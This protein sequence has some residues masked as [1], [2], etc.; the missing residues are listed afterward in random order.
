MESLSNF[1]DPDLPQPGLTF[2]NKLFEFQQAFYSS[3]AKIQVLES[4]LQELC[5]ATQSLSAGLIDRDNVSTIEINGDL[6]DLSIIHDVL[7]SDYNAIP[8]NF[9]AKKLMDINSR[10]AQSDRIQESRG[11]CIWLEIRILIPGQI[12]IRSDQP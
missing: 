6:L 12:I 5:I 3:D 7:K 4:L 2:L 10:F 8:F 11:D 9:E 1:F